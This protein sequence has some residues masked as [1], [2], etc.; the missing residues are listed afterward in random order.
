[1]KIRDPKANQVIEAYITSRAK[2]KGR[3]GSGD[4]KRRKAI[5]REVKLM[6]GK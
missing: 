3:G 2:E 1:M 6:F 5:G 4:R